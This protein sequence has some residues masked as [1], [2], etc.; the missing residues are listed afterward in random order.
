[1]DSLHDS[2]SYRITISENEVNVFFDDLDKGVLGKGEKP[3]YKFKSLAIK[4]K[5]E[6]FTNVIESGNYR[7]RYLEAE[8]FTRKFDGY[9]FR[10]HKF[11]VD[12]WGYLTLFF[13]VYKNRQNKYLRKHKNIEIELMPIEVIYH[14]E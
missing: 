12:S 6:D 9:S 8:E 11:S 2:I 10:S 4:Y 13:E 1:M 5:F 3:L 7:Y 14:W